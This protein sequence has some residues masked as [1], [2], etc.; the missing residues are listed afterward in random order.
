MALRDFGTLPYV[1]MLTVSVAEMRALEEL[2]ERDKELLLPYF[3]LRPWGV[4]HQLD[5][6]LNRIVEAYGD[7]PYLAD[8]CGPLVVN[9]D[10]RPVHAQLRSLKIPDDG[11]RNW[12]SLVERDANM[13]PVV[14]LA[15]LTQFTRQTERLYDLQRGLGLYLP[16]PTFG[17]LADITRTA[18]A[19]TDG[20]QDVI[21]ILDLGQRGPD[22]L[23]T[24][25]ATVG[26]VRTIRDGLPRATVVISAST[27]P[28]DF[29]GRPSQQIF[30]R[31][32]FE[33]VVAILGQNGLVYGDRGS[34]RAEKQMGGGGTPAPR[35]D[36]ARPGT[37]TFFR[38]STGG[39]DRIGAYVAQAR[40]AMKPPHWD[41]ALRVW[42]HQ[43]IERTAGNDRNA[44]KSPTS[45]TAV[46]INVHLHRQLFFRDP[47]AAYDT[48]EEWED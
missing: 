14:Q 19:L 3:Q 47:A 2:P 48:D 44:I 25:A 36:L 26:L 1:P 40:E 17:R 34:A 12:C 8:L 32:H 29:V 27:F 7:R 13:I 46:R 24:Q 28:S 11:Y 10:E 15:D 5:N 18:G 38:D 21:V 23:G 22:L 20:G 4:S 45:S 39:A 37:W 42:G 9:G 35:I 6:T 30:E 41:G 16:A 33:G 31:D 43:M